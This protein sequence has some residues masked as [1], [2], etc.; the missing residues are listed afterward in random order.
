M[1]LIEENKRLKRELKVAQE[2]R[3][4]LKKVTAYFASYCK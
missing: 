2:E 3:K 4:I 1:A